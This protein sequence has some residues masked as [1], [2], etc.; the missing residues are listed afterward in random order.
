MIGF[1]LPILARLGV[2]EGLRKAL[3][4][5][6]LAVAAI[7]L[8]WAFRALYD[9]SVT[10][11]H[12]QAVTARTNAR[13]AIAKEQASEERATDV[14]IINQAEK[15]R[16]DAIHKAQPS[17]PSAAAVALACARLR[18]SGTDTSRFPECRGS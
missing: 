3:G 8:L 7:A 12:D 17:K 14:I 18:K 6:T 5:A 9:R 13:D 1:L 4:Y 15:E 10:K 2:P 11:A 16:S